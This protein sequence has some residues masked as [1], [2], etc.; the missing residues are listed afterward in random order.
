MK[1]LQERFEENY[2]AVEKPA[3]NKD[4][5]KIEYV[6]YAPWYLWD[7]PEKQ[8]RSCKYR[9]L[10]VSLVGVA[11]YFLA[12][13]QQWIGNTR[14][15]LG[16]PAL[17]GLCAHVVELFGLILFC[18]AK[19]RT[20]KMTYTDVN[21]MVVHGSIARVGMMVL[22]VLAALTC[23]IRSGFCLEGFTALLGYAIGGITAVYV[24]KTYRQLKLRTERNTTLDELAAQGR[25]H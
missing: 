18:C 16:V 23:L 6:Y 8:L 24:Y 22:T 15:W 5:F 10:A 1:T 25:L 19:Y 17:L 9:L 21:R 7:L 12:G 11:F 20:T 2:A 14:L 13:A 3:K 4:G